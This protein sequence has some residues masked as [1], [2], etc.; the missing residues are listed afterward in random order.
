MSDGFLMLAQSTLCLKSSE[1]PRFE[2]VRG[3]SKEVA[4]DHSSNVQGHHDRVASPRSE[5][6]SDPPSHQ[7]FDIPGHVLVEKRVQG[8]I[9]KENV[10]QR[11]SSE[12]NSSA[13]SLSD[14][15]IESTSPLHEEYCDAYMTSTTTLS[16]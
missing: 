15:Q 5:S 8:D 9:L 13:S 14:G 4:E 11:N 6:P 7:N 3:E 16:D 12:D 10:V 2:Y 1:P